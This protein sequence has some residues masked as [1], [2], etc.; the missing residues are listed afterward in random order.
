[1]VKL[2]SFAA[3]FV[4]LIAMVMSVQGEW[5]ANGHQSTTVH[6]MNGTGRPGTTGRN[7]GTT[8]H[9]ITTTHRPNDGHN[10]H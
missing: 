10:N 9:P 1:M 5:S 4:V 3:I 6:P 2:F 8:G 7:A